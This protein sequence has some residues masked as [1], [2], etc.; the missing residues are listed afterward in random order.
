MLIFQTLGAKELAVYV[1]ATA[2]PDQYKGIT[3]TIDSLLL[4]RFAK[5]KPSLIKESIWKKSIIYFVFLT[6]FAAIY[7]FAAPYIF[8]LLY[9]AYAESVFLSQIYVLGIVFVFGS[10]PFSA[11]KAEMN[12]KIL[13]TYKFVFAVFQILSLII[14]MNFY[15]LLGAVVARILHRAFVCV[16]GYYL[17]FLSRNTAL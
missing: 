13:Y 1:F 10:I 5:Q 16:Y 7:Y 3:K 12:N 4:P 6:F 2:I 8:T 17:Y 11:M 9:P 14:L 15:G